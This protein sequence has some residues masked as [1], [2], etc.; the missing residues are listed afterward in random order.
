MSPQL[1]FYS[2]LMRAV[3]LVF[4]IGFLLVTGSTWV[5]WLFAAVCAVLLAATV[6]QIWSTMKDDRSS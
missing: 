6:W 4:F 2:R 5:N 1:I 3:V